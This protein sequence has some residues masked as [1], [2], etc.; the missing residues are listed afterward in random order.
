MATLINKNITF[1]GT[2]FTIRAGSFIFEDS[3]NNRKLYVHRDRI[4][5]VEYNNKNVIIGLD[6]GKEITLTDY[7]DGLF[8]K[9]IDEINRVR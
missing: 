2:D 3:A 9:I 1:N 4:S 8:D 7:F 6:N 5:A